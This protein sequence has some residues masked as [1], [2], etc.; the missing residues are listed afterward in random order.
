VNRRSQVVERQQ[1]MS[2]SSG[3]SQTE[4]FSEKNPKKA[5]KPLDFAVNF[6]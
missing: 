2:G 5:K 6:L 4:T 3:S 1:L